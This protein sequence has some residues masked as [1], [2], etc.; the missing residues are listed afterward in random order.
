V[1]PLLVI[2]EKI[3]FETVVSLGKTG[4]ALKIH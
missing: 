3:G 4:I 1:E 2:E